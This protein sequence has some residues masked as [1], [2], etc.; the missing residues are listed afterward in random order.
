MTIRIND[1]STTVPQSWNAL[2]LRLQLIC[3][4]ILMSDLPSIFEPGELLHA[5]K[6]DLA[7]AL[8]DLD[9]AFLAE[10][11]AGNIEEHG[12]EDGHLLFLSELDDVLQCA[13]FLFEKLPPKPMDDGEADAANHQSAITS[14]QIRLSLTAN[15]FPV[16]ERPS[17]ITG[18]P[19]YYYGPASSLANLNIYELSTAFTLFEQF[20]AS[21]DESIAT[22]LIA[23]LWRPGKP[24]TPE[25]IRSAYQGDRRLPLQHHEATIER[26]EPH[27]ATLPK[28]VRQLL[29]FWFACCREAIVNSYPAVFTRSGG[30]GEKTGRSYGWGGVLLSLAGGLVHLDAVA[31]QPHQNAFAYLSYLED[32]RQKEKLRRL[33]NK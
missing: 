22:K 29:L 19:I 26:R 21:H 5:K 13:N 16:L 8:L 28:P 10:W 32:E 18:K 3:Y 6:L 9:D 30:D 24:K 14:Y 25:N 12:K 2:P 15:P 33:S 17:N 23:T 4:G 20:M 1:R 31:A 7:K 11:E 27:M